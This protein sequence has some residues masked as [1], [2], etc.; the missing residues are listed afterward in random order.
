MGSVQKDLKF[1]RKAYVSVDVFIGI[2]TVELRFLDGTSRHFVGQNAKDLYEEMLI[3]T[4]PEF[5]REVSAP[6]TKRVVIEIIRNEKNFDEKV[7]EDKK[8]KYERKT[9]D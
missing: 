7:Y 4:G 2:E 8:R 5:I 6:T 3:H 1:V 9:Y